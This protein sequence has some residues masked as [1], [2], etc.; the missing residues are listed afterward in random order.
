MEHVEHTGIVKWFN[1]VK[2][3][4]FITMDDDKGDIFVHYTGITGAGFRKLV[5]GDRVRFV[6]ANGEKGDEARS[7][8]VIEP[9]T[10]ARR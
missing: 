6:I 2:G 8:E 5:E 10:A 3:F 1:N 7:V 9:Q 4:G